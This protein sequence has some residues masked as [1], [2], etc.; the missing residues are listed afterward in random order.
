MSKPQRWLDAPE[1]LSPAE[2]RVVASQSLFDPPAAMQDAIWQALDAR[3]APPPGSPE[4]AGPAA[5]EPPPAGPLAPPPSAPAA[6]TASFA[7]GKPLAIA[8]TALALVG[9]G[10][11]LYESLRPATA[12]APTASSRRELAPAEAPA[13]PFDLVAPGGP[14]EGLRNAPG[15]SSD[16]VEG[17]RNAPADA[18]AEGLRNA[19]GDAPRGDDA[20]PGAPPGNANDASAANVTNAGN[21]APAL[22][23]PA[24]PPAS[25]PPPPALLGPPEA[26]RARAP[27]AFEGERRLFEPSVTAAVASALPPLARGQGFPPAPN[28]GPGALSVSDRDAA[29]P[30]LASPT[31]G[32]PS[33]AGPAAALPAVAP[34]SP[35]LASLPANAP[36]ALAPPPPNAAPGVGAPGGPET[37][38]RMRVDSPGGTASGGFASARTPG[39]APAPAPVAE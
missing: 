11:G 20:A 15:N 5:P 3:L 25:P 6:G 28:T 1:Q 9:G 33:A 2:R 13:A 8:F 23:R 21:A 17:L 12:R 30:P 34:P 24:S 16:P 10:Y 19:P 22:A 32:A 38:R 29:L 18:P 7:L 4:P 36:P 37:W 26:D 27:G 31:P 39:A 35:P 14:A